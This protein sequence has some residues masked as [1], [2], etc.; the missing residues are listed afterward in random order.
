[1]TYDQSLKS[2]TYMG[3]IPLFSPFW[4]EVCQ[5][6]RVLEVDVEALVQSAMTRT[7]LHARHP[8]PGWLMGRHAESR[9]M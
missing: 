8:G 5:I 4:L 2:Q 1:M 9:Q 6:L 7:P 3:D